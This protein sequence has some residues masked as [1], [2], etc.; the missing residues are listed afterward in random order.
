ML[1]SRENNRSSTKLNLQE[2]SPRV[3]FLFLKGLVIGLCDS[4]PGVSGG[5]MAVIT[6]VYERL[7]FSIGSINGD[8]A[9]L[10]LSG[11]V[12]LTWRKVNGNFLLVLGLGIVAGLVLSANTVLVLFQYYPKIL[13]AFFIGL[14][15]MS[16]WVL[17]SQLESRKTKNWAASILGLV[18]ILVIGH[19]DPIVANFSYL[20][21]FFSGMVGIC[22]MILPGLSGALILILLGVYEFVLR[23]LVG[24]D[25]DYIMTFAIGCLCGLILFSKGLTFL[26]THHKDLT[27]AVII[28]MMLGSVYVL[29]PWQIM[30]DVNLERDAGQHAGQRIKLLPLNYADL[31][32]AS[33]MIPQ[34]IFAMN[35][36]M[37]IVFLLNKIS[38]G[39]N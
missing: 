3:R 4:V 26:L 14:I 9:G 22:A 35:L 36:G 28:G 34:I 13:S 1:G 6:N 33:A 10:L 32:G 30:A 16:V 37:L 24:L 39:K 38:N 23:A 20:Y 11:N 29:W 27:Y 8:A 5:T 2:S 7:V 12:G 25:L 31:T 17:E 18:V 15:L 21:I 19:V